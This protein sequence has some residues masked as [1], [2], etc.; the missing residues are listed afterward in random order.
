MIEK[1]QNLIEDNTSM[2]VTRKQ[3]ILGVSVIGALLL[4]IIFMMFG[5]G[6]PSENDKSYTPPPPSTSAPVH[7]QGQ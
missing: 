6:G 4:L 2:N 5:S 1:I 3:V 7:V